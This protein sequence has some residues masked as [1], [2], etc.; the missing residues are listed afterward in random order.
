M[1]PIFGTLLENGKN[2]SLWGPAP[3]VAPP[4]NRVCGFRANRPRH[5][6][7]E[8]QFGAM[9]FAMETAQG[10]SRDKTINPVMA[11]IQLFLQKE[12]LLQCC[13]VKA[14]REELIADFSLS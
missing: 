1:I 9:A 11:P 13:F 8:T 3:A 4:P 14:Q 7:A 10:K 6:I 12:Q 2:I 5:A